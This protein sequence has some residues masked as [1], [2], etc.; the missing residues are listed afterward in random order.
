ALKADGL[1]LLTDVPTAY[2]N[3]GTAEAR[4]IRH[5]APAELR[6]LSFAVGSMGPKIE[7]ACRFVETTGGWAAIGALDDAGSLVDHSAGTIIRR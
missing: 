4:P 6:R 1:L 3:W 5:A 2:V 7:A